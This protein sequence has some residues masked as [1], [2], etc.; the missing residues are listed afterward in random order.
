MILTI[1][2]APLL[3]LERGP[4]NVPLLIETENDLYKRLA[5]HFLLTPSMSTDECII[6]SFF[7]V[8]ILRVIMIHENSAN[9]NVALAGGSLSNSTN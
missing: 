8:Y 6:V 1:K 7:T 3:D 4:V 9:A 2:W 5:A